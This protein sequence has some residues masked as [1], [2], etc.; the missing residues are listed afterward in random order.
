MES[1]DPN[2]R[3]GKKRRRYWGRLAKNGGHN[4][5]RHLIVAQSTRL[6]QS[7]QQGEAPNSQPNMLKPKKNKKQQK[8][9]SKN[10]K[11]KNHSAKTQQNPPRGGR[12]RKWQEKGDVGEK[13][14]KNYPFQFMVL[15]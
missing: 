10:R 2:R 6:K 9:K 3:A 15:S 11:T 13:K 1:L 4:D 8:N 7:P 5:M 12:E 14:E